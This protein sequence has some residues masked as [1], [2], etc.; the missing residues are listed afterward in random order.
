MWDR[1]LDSRIPLREHEPTG[2]KTVNFLA[3]EQDWMRRGLQWHAKI[4]LESGQLR[5]TTVCE[6]LTGL[7]HCSRFLAEHGVDHPALAERPEELRILS[8]D[9]LG[10]LRQQRAAT[11]PNRGQP[12]SDGHIV[13]VMGDVEQFY[14]FMAD[15]RNEA[16]GRLGDHR[17]RH[18]GDEHA[19]LW[20]E[21]EK[22][23]KPRTAPQDA[24]IDDTAM[25]QIMANVELLGAPIAENGFG[26][27]QAMRL[28]MLLAL[29]GRRVSELSLLEFDCLLALEGLQTG[30]DDDG[31]IAKL[32]YQ[33]TK[34][35]GAP[36]TILVDRDVV[37]IIR[38][39]Q[40]WTLD[41]SEGAQ[42]TPTRGRA[43]CSCRA[44]ATAKATGPTP[45]R[46]WARS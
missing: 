32:R 44:S 46:R 41:S 7:K 31:A 15:H 38:A 1:R 22:P 33:Q 5:W 23:I 36:D 37:A 27:E 13:H 26:D 14:A 29:T 39:Q 40:A 2:K 34:I 10:Y 12:L 19:R 25:T 9:F 45:S 30:A 3:I 11:G 28:L 16:A 6:R 21:G 42:A 17:W 43:T 4:G 20:R 35:R 24:Y 18:L 8:L